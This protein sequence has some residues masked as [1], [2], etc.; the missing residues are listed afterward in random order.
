MHAGDNMNIRFNQKFMFYEDRGIDFSV[1]FVQRIPVI[2]S[3]VLLGFPFYRPVLLGI[4]TLPPGTFGDSH[5][6][7]RWKK[8]HRFTTLQPS[9][10]TKLSV[11]A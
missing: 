1:L 10:K 6:T 5:F 11:Q 2:L 7:T 4:S 9:S 3:S 8:K